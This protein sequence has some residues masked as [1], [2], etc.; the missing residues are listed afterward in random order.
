MS[1]SPSDV[2]A[3]QSAGR[4]V[5]KTRM[6]F[7]ILQCEGKT[8]KKTYE[9]GALGC[10]VAFLHVVL[11]PWLRMICIISVKQYMFT[12]YTTKTHCLNIN[13]V[14]RLNHA[15]HGGKSSCLP[16]YRPK[17]SCH[18]S[19]RRVSKSHMPPDFLIDDNITYHLRLLPL[20]DSKNARV[21]DITIKET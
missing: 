2:Y 9:L 3:H 12:F 14:L 18:M 4:P 16:L 20:R 21:K 6:I 1:F 19:H 17:S 15:K 5:R 7:R 11:I 13:N 10:G 8:A